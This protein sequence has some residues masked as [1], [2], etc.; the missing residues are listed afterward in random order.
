[1]F[2]LNC[3]GFTHMEYVG[4]VETDP[5]GFEALQCRG[6][7]PSHAQKEGSYEVRKV[8][9]LRRTRGDSIFVWVET[10]LKPNTW[11][12]PRRR[13]LL[14]RRRSGGRDSGRLAVC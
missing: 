10:C 1:M 5:C 9:F 6:L 7:A 14:H 3:I 12:G 13:G 2:Y 11:A 4:E 8:T